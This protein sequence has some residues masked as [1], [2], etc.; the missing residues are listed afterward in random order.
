MSASVGGQ[1]G[2]R[3][4]DRAGAAG[5]G[6]TDPA[7]VHPH[8]D[9]AVGRGGEHLDVDPV[10]ELRVVELHG[11]RDV[12][13][14]SAS[15]VRPG[16]TQAR[17]GLPTS[18]ATPV[19]RRPPT[20]GRRPLPSRLALPMS[21]VTSASVASTWCTVTGRGPGQRPDDE[22]VARLQSAG[23]QVVREHPHAVAAHLRRST[24]RRCGSPCTSRRRR[25]RRAAGRARRP[26]DG[27]GGGDPQHAVG[28]QPA[29]PVAQRGHRG[30]AERQLGLEVGQQHEVVL[31]AVALG[32]HPPD[33]DTCRHGRNASS[34]RPAPPRRRASGPGGRGETTTAAVARSGGCRRTS[35]RAPHA[36]RSAAATGVEGRDHLGVAERA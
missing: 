19:N 22:L 5:A 4:G 21:T 6:L 16:S 23:T 14:A 17:C 1:R 31:G 10:R 20:V 24:R 11:R 36:V 26:R 29:A 13:A 25:R 34:T 32:E 12:Q 30:G 2:D 7:F 33:Q 8:P 18:T 28:A 35:A 9:R 27:A 3:G 15:T